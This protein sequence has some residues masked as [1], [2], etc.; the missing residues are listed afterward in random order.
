MEMRAE[1]TLASGEREFT[2]AGYRRQME[3]IKAIDVY[4]AD[5]ARVEGI[6]G[7]RKVD[8]QWTR[9][10]KK[11][12]AHAW[13]TGITTPRS[14][15][16]SL[17]SPNP[18]IF[19]SKPFPAVVQDVVVAEKLWHKDGWTSPIHGPGLGIE[20]IEAEVRKIAP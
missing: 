7:F 9:Y 1:M 2:E 4:G 11:I 18:I 3:F 15:H 19:E 12:K 10:G 6:T 20:V 13:S 8:A 14:L 16:C 17:A 5:P